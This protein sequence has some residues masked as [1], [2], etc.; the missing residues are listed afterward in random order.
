MFRYRN[1]LHWQRLTNSSEDKEGQSTQ[2]TKEEQEMTIRQCEK[3]TSEEEP[4]KKMKTEENE[5]ELLEVNQF[6]FYIMM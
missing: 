4:C 3:D 5:M 6:T 1:H 2:S